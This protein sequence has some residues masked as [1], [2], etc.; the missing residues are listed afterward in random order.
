MLNQSVSFSEFIKTIHIL[1][2]VEKRYICIKIL[3]NGEG[4]D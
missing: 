2:V 1:Y 3:I 4:N